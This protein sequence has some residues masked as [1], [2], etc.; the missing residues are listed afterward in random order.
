MKKSKDINTLKVVTTIICF[1]LALPIMAQKIK[2][3]KK[4]KNYYFET[5]I[6]VPVD[7]IN[8]YEWLTEMTDI[9]YQSF[10]KGHKAMG[11]TKDGDFG[12]MVNLES[13]GGNL[14]VQHYKIIEAKNNFVYL[15]SEKTR[16]Y[17]FHLI[18]VNIEVTWSLK[19]I[20]VSKEKSKFIC[21]VGV[22]YPVK[23]LKWASSIT[24]SPFFIK[25]HVRKEGA[26]FAKDI[27]KKFQ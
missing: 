20:G 3:D 27:E 1:V 21:E 7:S 12:G 23:L 17:I 19:V 10:A 13:I 6:N 15:R 14:L 16:A 24:G 26:L 4:M 22:K 18:P 25:R 5:Q 9:E 8:L 11:H 2:K